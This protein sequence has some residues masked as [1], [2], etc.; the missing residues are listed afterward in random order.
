MQIGSL[1]ANL[2]V[3]SILS[4]IKLKSIDYVMLSII[5]VRC[6]VTFL[7]FKF[8]IEN[9]PGF[10]NIDLKVLNDSIIFIFL[11]TLQL[12][13]VNWKFDLLLTVPLA[14]AS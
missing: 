2:L 1:S 4:R 13:V 10:E 3:F 12:A 8:S 7:L 14:I 5:V 6:I 9:K 11:P